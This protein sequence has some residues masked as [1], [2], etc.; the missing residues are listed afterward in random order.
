MNTNAFACGC[1]FGGLPVA[2]DFHL[3]A[4]DRLGKTIPFHFVQVGQGVRY[5]GCLD[6]RAE[7]E[8]LLACQPDDSHLIS[9]I[10][11]RKT[12]TNGRLHI[13]RICLREMTGL[14]PCD[15]CINN[16]LRPLY[17]ATTCRVT[18]ESFHPRLG[19]RSRSSRPI[20][21][22]TT[23]DLQLVVQWIIHASCYS[24]LAQLCRFL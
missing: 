14:A 2:S 7:C 10:L 17:E 5:S 15:H 19:P 13:I 9:G 1:S 24:A 12:R 11:L 20:N 21:L 23:D 18:R 3:N 4:A 6:G 8:P 22:V 16:G